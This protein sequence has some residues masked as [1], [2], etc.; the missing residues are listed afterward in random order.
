MAENFATFDYK[1]VEEV[2]TVI[3]YL[4]NVLST[5][6]M[7]LLEILSPSHLLTHL[8]DNP[9]SSQHSQL[10]HPSFAEPSVQTLVCS[11]SRFS[12][13]LLTCTNTGP[14]HAQP[15]SERLVGY[16]GIQHG[17]SYANIC[18][19]SHGYAVESSPKGLILFI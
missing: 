17:G 3:K 16:K 8:H 6:G 19:Y 11:F 5:T 4:T 2:L 1:T 15:T 7:Q 9:Q 12:Y 14:P 10:I 13:L 18:Y